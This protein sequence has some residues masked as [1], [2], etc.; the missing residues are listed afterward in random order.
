[1][2]GVVPVSLDESGTLRVPR[3]RRHRQPVMSEEKSIRWNT[4]SIDA[5]SEVRTR[6]GEIAAAAPET[7]VA[8]HEV[9]VRRRDKGLDIGTR[10]RSEDDRCTGT[11]RNVETDRNE[12]LQDNGADRVDPV[13]ALGGSVIG[14][15]LHGS[16]PSSRV[17]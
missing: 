5:L 2:A 16:G 4:G 10:N 14:R 11:L 17:R 8:L 13:D 15:R 7:A 9:V 1:M 12:A 6:E 3:W